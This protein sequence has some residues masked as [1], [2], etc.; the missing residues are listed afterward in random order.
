[1]ISIALL[2]AIVMFGPRTLFIPAK[3]TTPSSSIDLG[4]PISTISDEAD[5]K[6]ISHY[7]ST[8]ETIGCLGKG[9]FGLV[10]EA[11]QK[12][13]ECSYAIKRITLPRGYGCYLFSFYFIYIIFI[14]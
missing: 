3:K 1:M 7:E 10:F 8:F 5:E 11:K 14:L 12:I 4:R 13:D 9:G 2:T 6:F